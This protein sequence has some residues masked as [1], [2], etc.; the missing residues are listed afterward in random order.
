MSSPTRNDWK[1]DRHS[2]STQNAQPTRSVDARILK[3]A[4]RSANS[5]YS[6]RPRAPHARH[7]TPTSAIVLPNHG[8]STA[9]S[10]ELSALPRGNGCG[11]GSR[12]A[13]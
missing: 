4:T 10:K 7:K 5:P 12:R 8:L 6:E 3:V 1:A 13:R 2:R 9:F 11:A